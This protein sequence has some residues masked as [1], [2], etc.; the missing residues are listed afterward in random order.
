VHATY[1]RPCDL[2]QLQNSS[3]SQKQNSLQDFAD[4]ALHAPAGTRRLER[5]PGASVLAHRHV[6]RLDGVGRVSDLADFWRKLEERND[7]RPSAVHI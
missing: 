4:T 5:A 2:P 6:H 3:A 7:V 1:I